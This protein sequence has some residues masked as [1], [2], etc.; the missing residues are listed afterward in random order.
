MRAGVDADV[1]EAELGAMTQDEVLLANAE[2]ELNAPFQGSDKY[3]ATGA[4]RLRK[5]LRRP[6]PK[7]HTLVLFR[8]TS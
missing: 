3:D 4:I 6:V 1:D 8:H 7:P 5:R 2:I